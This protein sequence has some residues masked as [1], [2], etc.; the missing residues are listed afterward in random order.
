MLANLGPHEFIRGSSQKDRY[1]FESNRFGHQKT[2]DV[3]GKSIHCFLIVN[4]GFICRDESLD[5]GV[6]L[7]LPRR[8]T[9][10]HNE[11]N[12]Q[13]YFLGCIK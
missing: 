5:Y 7:Y 4:M 1:G 9:I 6:I 3:L 2:V 11:A 8:V 13:R 12:P 10:H